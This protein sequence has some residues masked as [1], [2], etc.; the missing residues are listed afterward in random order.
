MGKPSNLNLPMWLLKIGDI[1]CKVE[2]TFKKVFQNVGYEPP[3]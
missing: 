2:T 3:L 1:A